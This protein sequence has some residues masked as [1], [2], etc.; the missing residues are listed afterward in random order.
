LPS[1]KPSSTEASTVPD[2]EADFLGSLVES[3]ARIAATRDEQAILERAC[4]EAG[5]LLDATATRAAPGSPPP[6][7][8]AAVPIRV[9]DE[10]LGSIVLDRARPFARRELLRAAVLADMA[11]RAVENAR[12]LAEAQVRETE[13]SLLSERLITAEQDERR[14]LA[15]F[16]HD[17]ALQALSGIGLMLEAVSQSVEAGRLEEARNVL[18]TAL[19][20]HREAIRSL[21]DLSFNLEPVVLRDQ[22]FGPAV[23]AL[24]EQI[25]L[26]HGIRIDLDA[27]PA[28]LLPEQT[29]VVLYQIVREALDLMLRRGP[30]SLVAISVVA[31]PERSV[32][33]TIASDGAGERRR[34]SFDGIAERARTI[35]GTIVVEIREGGGTTVTVLLP[36]GPTRR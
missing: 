20:R 12:L 36:A 23:G 25:G 14:R 3:G 2:A 1:E 26:S 4:R 24:A 9:G 16:L 13:R 7:G 34:A 29:Q 5:V 22:G 35:G 8:A 11:A 21:R 19:E 15:L 17:G 10:E 28:D 18:G 30:P 27:E 6:D 32:V 33:A 31:E